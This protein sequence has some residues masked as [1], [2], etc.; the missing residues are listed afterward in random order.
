MPQSKTQ[1]KSDLKISFIV[2]PSFIS[3]S[4]VDVIC[5]KVVYFSNENSLLA[6]TLPVLAILPK[7]FLRRSTIIIFSALFFRLKKG[8]IA[9]KPMKGTMQIIRK[10]ERYPRGV[11]C[12][13]IGYI[14]PHREMCFNV[15]IR[16]IHLDNRGRGV[17]GV[18]G[19]IVYDSKDKS[20]YDEA[21]LKAKFFIKKQHRFSLIETILWDKSYYLLDYHLERLHHSCKYFGIPF[22]E[23]FIAD[24]LNHL[25]SFFG[26]EYRYKVRLLLNHQGSIR[27]FYSPLANITG[28][29]SVMLSADVVHSDNLYLYHKTTNRSF[30]DKQRKQA[31]GKGA[32]ESIFI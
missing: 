9:T 6:F 28:P 29:V 19:G 27:C 15:A 16:T 2:I 22:R 18:G 30:Y 13:A 10:V 14:S 4:I 26:Q 32:W 8:K 12:G 11:Y 17:L 7:S 1:G 5:H 31:L 20:E 3:A 24:K 21:I 25:I 23:Y